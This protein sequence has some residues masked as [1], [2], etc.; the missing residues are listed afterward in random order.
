MS[1][2]FTGLTLAMIPGD[3]FEVG[4]E[5]PS[6]IG[7]LVSEARKSPDAMVATFAIGLLTVIPGLVLSGAIGIFVDHI[8]DDGQT[9]WLPWLLGS[10]VA[11]AAIMAGL[12]FLGGRIVAAFKAKVAAVSAIE[13]FWHA[14]FLP[15]SF[16][17]QRSAGEV[18]SRLRL[19]V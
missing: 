19:G 7:K 16:F 4:G 1:A 14:L 8:A 6:V 3:E 9:E 2:S 13:C 11:V 5:R 17:S 18:V 15:L 12:S 10:L